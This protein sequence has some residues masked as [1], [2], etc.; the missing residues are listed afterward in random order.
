[1]RLV[2]SFS[3]TPIG[4]GSTSLSKYVKAAIGVLKRRGVAYK[5]GP[6]HTDFEARDYTE[7]ADVLREV[8][9]TL[10]AAGVKRIGVSVKIDDRRDKENSMESKLGSVF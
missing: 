9:D 10:F 5:L 2:V 6:S 8:S 3:V 1:M 4:T 7:M